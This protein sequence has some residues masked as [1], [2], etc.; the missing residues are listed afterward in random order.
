MKLGKPLRHDLINYVNFIYMSPLDNVM[1]R[2]YA[3]GL[4]GW[5]A[6]RLLKDS[7][8]MSLSWI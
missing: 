8:N 5:E 7:I 3:I 6:R 4:K 1:F 2:A